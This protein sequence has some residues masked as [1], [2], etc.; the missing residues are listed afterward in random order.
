MEIKPLK[1]SAVNRPYLTQLVGLFLILLTF[2]IMLVSISQQNLQKQTAT[3]NSVM[4]AFSGEV[5]QGQ[6]EEDILRQQVVAGIARKA[7]G[8]M[9]SYFPGGELTIESHKDKLALRLPLKAFFAPQK[10]SLLY[11]QKP[12]ITDLATLLGHAISGVSQELAVTLYTT[13]NSPA[14]QTLALQRAGVLTRSLLTAG[15]PVEQMAAATALGKKDEIVL[16]L[17]VFITDKT[18]AMRYIES[19]WQTRPGATTGAA[20]QNTAQ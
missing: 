14:G 5:D 8:N 15:A 6:S 20:G 4:Q 11:A 12:F 16:Y 18:A 3:T 1:L 10:S 17:R 2:F 19:L 9:A 7:Y 13:D